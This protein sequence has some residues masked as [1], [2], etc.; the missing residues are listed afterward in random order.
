LIEND[1]QQWPNHV[2]ATVKTH[3]KYRRWK[4]KPRLHGKKDDWNT[5]KV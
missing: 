3:S 5:W 1:E 4:K 2:S